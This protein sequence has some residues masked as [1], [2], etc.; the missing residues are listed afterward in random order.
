MDDVL[1]IGTYDNKRDAIT[2]VNQAGVHATTR[3]S[4]RLNINH[5][6]NR[7]GEWVV[8][9]SGARETIAEF[10]KGWS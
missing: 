4:K 6:E 5:M 10:K 1:K 2:R 7:R 8:T 9:V 3:C